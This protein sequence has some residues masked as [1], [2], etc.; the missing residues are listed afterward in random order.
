MK[1]SPDLE[2]RIMALS[3]PGTMAR[4]P[5]S[6][7]VARGEQRP[8]RSMNKTEAAYGAFLEGEK[9]AGRVAWYRF[10]GMTLKLADDCRYTPDFTVMRADGAMECHEVK[11]FWRDDARVKIRVAASLYPFRFVAVTKTKGGWDTEEF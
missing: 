11:G 5:E 4:P 2:A 6:L 10:E 8:P 3:G 9:Y 7:P 1:V